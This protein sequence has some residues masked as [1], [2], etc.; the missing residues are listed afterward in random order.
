MQ[1][2]FKIIDSLKNNRSEIISI[3]N[4]IGKKINETNAKLKIIYD[5]KIKDNEK[6][7]K[8]FQLLDDN[9][10]FKELDL[11][12]ETVYEISDKLSDINNILDRINSILPEANDISSNNIIDNMYKQYIFPAFF[13]STL[14]EEFISEIH[15]YRKNLLVFYKGSKSPINSKNE[16]GKNVINYTNFIEKKIIDIITSGSSL[17]N[18]KAVRSSTTYIFGRQGGK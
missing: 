13:M 2:D 18:G 6:Y 7:E 11:H 17:S 15:D 3:L 14:R 8:Y 5:K 10:A 4:L 16:V 1:Y 9:F 12:L